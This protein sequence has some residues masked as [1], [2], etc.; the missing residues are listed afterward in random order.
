MPHLKSQ[1]KISAWGVRRAPSV[2]PAALFR[3]FTTSDFHF[4]LLIYN[5]NSSWLTYSAALFSGVEFSD[6][7]LID[8]GPE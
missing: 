1:L 3:G 5:V 7:L 8:L 2:E 6:S 4:F